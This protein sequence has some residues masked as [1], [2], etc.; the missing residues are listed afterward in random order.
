MEH[1]QGLLAFSQWLASMFGGNP[2][3]VV[4]WFYIVKNVFSEFL[5]L[6]LLLL[7]GLELEKQKV[8]NEPKFR[9]NLEIKPNKKQDKLEPI[10]ANKIGFVN[11]NEKQNDKPKIEDFDEKVRLYM[12]A[13]EDEKN[14]GV[15]LGYQKISKAIG[16][17]NHEASKIKGHLE[18]IGVLKVVE[19]QTRII[20]RN[21]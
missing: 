8:L 5:A 2:D 6:G 11:P 15:C 20:N 4:G 16:I 21:I 14:K 13:M 12:S 10:T 18:K 1:T 3:K 9:E 7:G 17:T 19:G